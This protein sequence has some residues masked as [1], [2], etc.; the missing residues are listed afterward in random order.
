M[1]RNRGDRFLARCPS[2]TIE[3]KIRAA[4]EA[5]GDHLLDLHVWRLGPG[6][7]GAV[8]S[9]VS[10]VAQR[11][12]SFYHEAFHPIKGLSHITVEV[13]NRAQIERNP[14]GTEPQR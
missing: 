14:L 5:A 12:P 8:V 6:H 2:D 3:T 11:G 10:S 1:L 4:I 9:V 7:F 13:H